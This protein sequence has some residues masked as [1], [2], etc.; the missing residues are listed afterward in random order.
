MNRAAALKSYGQVH[1]GAG[2]Q[3]ASSH[4]LIAM[5]FEGLLTRIAQAKGCIEQ[6]DIE[7]KG[8]KITEA[9]N[10]IM[11][12]RDSLDL[13]QGG[14]LAMNLEALYDY[15]QRTLMQAHLKNDR[16]KLDE[17]RDLLKQVSSAWEEMDIAS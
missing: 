11:G 14:E 8:K 2:V 12:L 6:N 5:L 13:E 9:M 17:C 4:R 10:I 16:E 15:V 7:T 1:I 3:G